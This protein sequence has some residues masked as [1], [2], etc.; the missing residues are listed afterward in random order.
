M[1]GPLPGAR[2][3][4]MRK[5]TLIKRIKEQ[6]ERVEKAQKKLLDESLW[7]GVLQHELDVIEAGESREAARNVV[8][9]I[10]AKAGHGK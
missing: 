2:V 7:L 9:N 8:F 1:P 4:K 10:P 6:T 5:D 3:E